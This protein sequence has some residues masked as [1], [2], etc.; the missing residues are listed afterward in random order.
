MIRPFP[1]ILGRDGPVEEL[2]SG[3]GIDRAVVAM[4]VAFEFVAALIAFNS[5][6]TPATVNRHVAPRAGCHF[7]FNQRDVGDGWFAHR[8]VI[9]RG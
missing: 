5:D 9:S 1:A 4:H 6:V 3:S 8:S 2:H 7:Q